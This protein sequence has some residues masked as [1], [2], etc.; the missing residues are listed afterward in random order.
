MS[1]R[2]SKMTW[3]SHFHHSIYTVSLSPL[4]LH[5]MYLTF[6]TQFTLS[7]FPHS[8]C[9]I[10]LSPL[11]LHYLTFTTQFTLSP[12]NLHYLTFTT[13][14]PLSHFHHLIQTKKF[15]VIMMTVIISW[16]SLVGFKLSML[17]YIQKGHVTGINKKKKG[18]K[19]YLSLHI[20]LK[21]YDPYL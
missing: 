14:F 20:T 16:H 2:D 18:W 3:L 6:T 19:L 4:N 7:H 15:H 5:Y 8:I 17:P 1:Q 9:T 12:L 11:N 10:S 13:Q 21:Y